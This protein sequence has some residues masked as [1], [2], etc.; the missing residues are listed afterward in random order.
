MIVKCPQ[1]GSDAVV[2]DGLRYLRDSSYVQRFYCKM[3]GYRFSDSV[4]SSKAYILPYYFNTI[5]AHGEKIL[6]EAQRQIEKWQ[7]GGTET[8]QQS[9][10][11]GKILEFLW[12][13]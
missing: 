6:M 7:A 5:D 2:K 1:C 9:D 3:C 12:H 11:K 4:K 8:Q 10:V 13:L